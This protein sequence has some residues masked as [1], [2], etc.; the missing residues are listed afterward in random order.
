MKVEEIKLAF[1]TNIQF[2]QLSD[3]AISSLMSFL[4]SD[5]QKAYDE[6]DLAIKALDTYNKKVDAVNA[7]FRSIEKGE[8][9]K[10]YNDIIAKAKE[11][12]VTPNSVKGLIELDKTYYRVKNFVSEL[13]KL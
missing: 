3:N 9:L 1:E 11:L 8:Y 12:D 2:T 5:L 13:T 4:S 6:K 10:A 7:K